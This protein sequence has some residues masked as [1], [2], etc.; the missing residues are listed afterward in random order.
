MLRKIGGTQLMLKRIIQVR[1]KKRF[2]FLDG[3]QML[4][5]FHF[6]P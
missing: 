3:V 2:G 6:Q 4:L 1:I 5:I